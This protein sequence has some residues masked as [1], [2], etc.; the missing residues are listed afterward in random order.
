MS[1]SSTDQDRHPLLQESGSQLIKSLREHP[2]APRFTDSCGDWLDAAGLEQVRAF[3]KELEGL[4][5][6]WSPGN[7]PA[8]LEDFIGFCRREVPAYRAYGPA[9]LPFDRLPVVTRADLSR[10]PWNFVPDSQ[11]L[12]DLVLYH[13]SGSTGHPLDVL[14]HPVVASM[15]LPLIRMALARRGV[16][17]AGGPGKVAMA[18][19]CFQQH[20]ITC[21]S[22]SAFLEQAG[23]VK[24]NLNPLDWRDPDDRARYLDAIAPEVISG[25]PLSF[26][27]LARL[28]V[29]LRPAAL[30]STSMALLPAFHRQLEERFGCPVI[31]LYS[32]NETGP[33]AAGVPGEHA[34][35]PHRLYVEILDPSGRECGPG[36]R[37][38]VTLTGGFNPF[39]PLL[40]YRTGDW[41]SLEWRGGSPVLVGLQGRPPVEFAGENGQ[42][43]NNIDVTRALQPFALAQFTLHQAASGALTLGVVGDLS[44]EAAIRSALVGLFG[45]GLLLT[46]QALDPAAAAGSK[47][48]QYTRDL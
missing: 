11:P 45:T 2:N 36:E 39:L 48:V 7:R 35:L 34:L 33:V 24:V 4:D 16:R 44:A 21:V 25:D 28:P 9:E 8:W 37:G 20:T 26:D 29:R 1:Q 14:S 41:A 46:I 17:L 5:T 23:F 30:V 27:E 32:L 47:L 3:Q 13:T 19:V 12:T 40:R 38:E 31:D 18:M 42:R 10:A 43:I 6:G 15:H 22:I